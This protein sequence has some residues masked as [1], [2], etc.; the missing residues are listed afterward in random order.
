MSNIRPKSSDIEKILENVTKLDWYN[1][2]DINNNISFSTGQY[3]LKI[4]HDGD[5]WT[6]HLY[7][8]ESEYGETQA[9]WAKGPMYNAEE[10]KKELPD[11]IPDEIS[12]Q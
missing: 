11:F 6:L 7:D 12:N 4:K 2:K 10:I 9:R 8:F 5:Y 1:T 3:N